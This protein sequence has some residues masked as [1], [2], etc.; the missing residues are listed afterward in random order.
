M[1]EPTLDFSKIFE[2]P[3]TPVVLFHPAY[4]GYAVTTDFDVTKYK[5]NTYAYSTRDDQWFVSKLEGEYI[6]AL[7]WCEISSDVV[8][9]KFLVIIENEY[10]PSDSV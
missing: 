3:P 10:C 7:F 2:L 9:E 8:P 4:E 5:E 1:F 6:I